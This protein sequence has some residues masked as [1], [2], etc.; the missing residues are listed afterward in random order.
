MRPIGRIVSSCIHLRLYQGFYGVPEGMMRSLFRHAD[1]ASRQHLQRETRKKMTDEQL[2]RDALTNIRMACDEHSECVEGDVA[3]YSKAEAASLP[4]SVSG[5]WDFVIVVRHKGEAERALKRINLFWKCPYT[6]PF[7]LNDFIVWRFPEV[8]DQTEREVRDEPLQG[9]GFLP[10]VFAEFIQSYPN[11]RY[12]PNAEAVAL[13][14]DTDEQGAEWYLGNYF[15]RSF[16]EAFAIFDRL[17]ETRREELNL[18]ESVSIL[19]LGIGSGGAMAG[20]IWALRKW[21]GGVIREV[22][23]VGKEVNEHAIRLCGDIMCL[24]TGDHE[25]SCECGFD[26]KLQIQ[27][28]VDARDLLSCD[29]ERRYDFILASK[30][31]QEMKGQFGYHDFVALSDRLLKSKGV[32]FLLETFSAQRQAL[33]DEALTSIRQ[34]RRLLL[35]SQ[36]MGATFGVISDLTQ[37]V[38]VESVLFAVWG[39]SDLSIND[40]PEVEVVCRKLG[41]GISFKN[42]RPQI[43]APRVSA[44]ALADARAKVAQS[45]REDCCMAETNPAV[46][47]TTSFLTVSVGDAGVCLST[48]LANGDVIKTFSVLPT[49]D[50]LKLCKAYVRKDEATGAVRGRVGSK[51]PLDLTFGGVKQVATKPGERK[52]FVA[53]TMSWHCAAADMP[54]E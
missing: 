4:C 50:L 2:V 39:G 10:P 40:H 51:F 43:I 8:V 11:A 24:L 41:A 49:N 13:N 47:T 53:E 16:C 27:N 37:R 12:H 17:F 44:R 46:V 1:F 33:A 6:K 38:M 29:T 25:V 32:S 18:G 35:C 30:A 28:G 20:L 34:A 42:S 19:D 26:L 9:L 31:I 36:P 23:V 7:V 52:Q 21:Y 14:Q 22:R 45:T 15:P 48:V 5:D 3:M 54:S